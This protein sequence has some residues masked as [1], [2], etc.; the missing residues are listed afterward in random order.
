MIVIQPVTRHQRVQSTPYD[1]AEDAILRCDAID[2]KGLRIPL[3]SKVNDCRLGDSDPSGAEYR[4][5]LK[6]IVE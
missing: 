4:T 2:M 1:T 5:D 3:E 6:F